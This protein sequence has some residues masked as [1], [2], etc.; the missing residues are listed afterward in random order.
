[1]DILG[2]VQ[3]WIDLLPQSKKASNLEEAHKAAQEIDSSFDLL[4]EWVPSDTAALGH[5]HLRPIRKEWL[6]LS[7]KQDPQ[8]AR[9]TRESI[10]RE[11]SAELEKIQEL[12]QRFQRF[13]GDPSTLEKSTQLLEYHLQEIQRDLSAPVDR[14][15]LENLFQGH[16]IENITK[17][18]P[19]SPPET[20]E[21][22]PINHPSSSSNPPSVSPP[23]NPS[24]IVPPEESPHHTADLPSFIPA[25]LST[26]LN[27][28][29][30]QSS[31][32]DSTERL[33]LFNRILH[34]QREHLASSGNLSSSELQTTSLL[35]PRL[36][37]RLQTPFTL[38]EVISGKLPPPPLSVE[39][40]EIARALS[41]ETIDLI[42]MIRL[43]KN[44]WLD[45]SLEN[46]TPLT[47]EEIR[48]HLQS[49]H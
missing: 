28:V 14:D 13:G 1:M 8:H 11:L 44:N 27:F 19:T 25:E 22:I 26:L 23:S 30:N 33:Q 37:A 31:L 48:E 20:E 6:A 40:K 16:H 38:E 3:N 49:N 47:R 4:V 35:T 12:E 21:N 2:A 42:S 43:T 41:Q 17:Y 36:K 18:V 32:K 5:Y 10:L 45:L 9:I 34:A 24:V 39:A 29:N 7:A 46:Q 15:F